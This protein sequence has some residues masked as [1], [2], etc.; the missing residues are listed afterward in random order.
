MTVLDQVLKH[1]DL[2]PVSQDGRA[3]II[4][5]HSID[6]TIESCARRFEFKHVYGYESR[7]EPVGLA[8]DVGTAL[9]EAAQ[10]FTRSWDFDKAAM[11]LLRWWPWKL[12]QARSDAGLKDYKRTLGHALLLLEAICKHPIWDEW[13]PAKLP[14]GSPAIELPWRMNHISLGSFKHPLTGQELFLATQGKID[15]ILQNR[16]NPNRKMVA[17][18]KTTVLDAPAQQA[19]FRFSGQ[20][21]QYG[22]VVAHAIG[23]NWQEHG[24]EVCYLVAEFGE[25]GEPSVEAL[26]YELDAIELW[27]SLEVKNDRLKR[28]LEYGRRGHW[29]RRTHGC[30]FYGTPCGFLEICHRRDPE[31]LYLWFAHERTEEFKRASRIYEPFW[32]MET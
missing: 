17:D 3:Y 27:E 9:H 12:E 22:V 25:H 26:D 24:I 19:S 6:G 28:M 13:E 30:A 10:E 29:S 8:A 5:S 1:P 4:T 20:A 31:F 11:T 18:L 2:I 15:W 7:L 21:G 23:Q 32:T 16:A 14:D